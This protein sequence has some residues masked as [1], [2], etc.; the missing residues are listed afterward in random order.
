MCGFFLDIEKCFDSCNHEIILSKLDHYGVRGV[1]LEWF[2]SYLSN[3]YQFVET[4]RLT[5]SKE[6]LVQIGIPQ[7]SILGPLLM[8]VINNDLHRSL[9]LGNCVLFAD[10]TTVFVLGR[11]I[12]FLMA[13]MQREIDLVSEWMLDNF[14]AVN[15]EKTK[16][17][18]ITPKGFIHQTVNCKCMDKI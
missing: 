8:C 17:M 2:K 16:V 5:Q 18:L 3:R 9:K 15:V 4:D 10:D 14:L 12:K 1:A 13:K 11:N 6:S 7:G